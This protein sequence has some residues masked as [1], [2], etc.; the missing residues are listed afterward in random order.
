[1]KENFPKPTLSPKLRIPRPLTKEELTPDEVQIMTW[2]A[3]GFMNKEISL[4]L[5]ISQS[6]MGRILKNIFHK[7]G[8]ENRIS[9]IVEFIIRQ[10]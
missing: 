7:L 4:H 6:K 10:H 8:V 1:M 5:G 3:Q 2:L 9:A